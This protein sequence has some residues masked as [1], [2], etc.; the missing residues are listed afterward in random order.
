MK[1]SQFQYT[2]LFFLPIQNHQL[3][4]NSALALASY[5]VKSLMLFSISVKGIFK[6]QITVAIVEIIIQVHGA[7]LKEN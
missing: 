2:S 5:G 6:L 3:T 1:N 4:F 7:A